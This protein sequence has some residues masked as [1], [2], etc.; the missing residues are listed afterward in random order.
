MLLTL[1]R[2]Q[3]DCNITVF[4][5]HYL[6]A[7]SAEHFNFLSYRSKSGK[8]TFREGEDCKRF[9]GAGLHSVL[10]LV[11]HAAWREQSF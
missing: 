1:S 2:G 8:G 10:K 9:A 11:I 4:P 3:R 7:I 5:F 6:K